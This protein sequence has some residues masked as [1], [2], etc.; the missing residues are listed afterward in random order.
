MYPC[1]SQ[2]LPCSTLPT[3]RF[4]LRAS[5]FPLPQDHKYTDMVIATLKSIRVSVAKVYRNTLLF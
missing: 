1:F 4:M 5:N 3:S 2:T